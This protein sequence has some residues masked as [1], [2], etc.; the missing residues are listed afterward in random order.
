VLE[1]AVLKVGWLRWLRKKA[2]IDV[3]FDV[4][5]GCANREGLAKIL[6]K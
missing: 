6:I 3:C 2:L 4:C 5:F 1:V